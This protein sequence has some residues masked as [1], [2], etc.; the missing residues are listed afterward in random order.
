[1][2]AAVTPRK[3]ADAPLGRWNRFH[4]TL[5]QDRVT[6]ILNGETIIENALLP[7]LPSRGPIGLQH[8]E[9]VVEFA[10]L[11]IREL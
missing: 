3:V 9:T 11:F 4:I 10:N 6:V 5:R 2:R 1:V 8:H 7:G